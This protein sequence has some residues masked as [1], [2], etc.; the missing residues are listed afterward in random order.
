MSGWVQA[1]M[2]QNTI[3]VF[4]DE[5]NIFEKNKHQNCAAHAWILS[6]FFPFAKS[7]VWVALG[8]AN[9]VTIESKYL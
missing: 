8:S 9:Q 1:N 2:Q 5:S 3:V 7:I 4:V 6:F